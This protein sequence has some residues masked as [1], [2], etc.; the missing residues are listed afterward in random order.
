MLQHH[1][2]LSLLTD[3][4]TYMFV[5]RRL[6]FRN[7]H[8]PHELPHIKLSASHGSYFYA[9]LKNHYLH[10]ETRLPHFTTKLNAD[11]LRENVRTTLQ[12][13][14]VFVISKTKLLY[15]QKCWFDE[16]K[17]KL[18]STRHEASTYS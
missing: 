7:C 9:I 18:R 16:G 17:S 4:L 1:L 6:L 15:E 14:G 3:T 5:L 13:L 11:K 2:Q 10:E 12:I 8:F